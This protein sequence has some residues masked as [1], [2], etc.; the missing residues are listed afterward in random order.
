MDAELESTRRQV[1]GATV[2]GR[3]FTSPP[4]YPAGRAPR[5]RWTGGWV[6]PRHDLDAMKNGQTEEVPNKGRSDAT[7]SER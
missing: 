1:Y 6:D 5:S 4:L 7:K 2:L 3:S